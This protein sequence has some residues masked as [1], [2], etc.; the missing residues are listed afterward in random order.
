MERIDM[1]EILELQEQIKNLENALLQL[2]KEVTANRE[3]I[4]RQADLSKKTV[5]ALQQLTEV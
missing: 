5:E 1:K 3:F 4:Q 2:S